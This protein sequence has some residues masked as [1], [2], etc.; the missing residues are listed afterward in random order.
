M[1]TR[2]RTQWQFC[3]LLTVVA[4]LVFCSLA[5]CNKPRTLA[6]TAPASGT[7]TYQGKPLEGATVMF[8]K[9]GQDLTSGGLATGTTDAQ[10][11][12]S[13]QSRIGPTDVV[14]GAIQG[15][16]EVIISK[17]I[18]PGGMSEEEYKQKLAEEERIMAEKGAVP[19]DKQ[20]PPKVEMLP[21]EYSDSQKSTLKATIPA[22]GDTGLKFNLK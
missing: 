10:G 5:G 18:P 12:F 3:C 15:E 4:G 16:Y 8:R 11:N 9:Q 1:S 2:H 21:A 20:A 14:D 17:F 22:G 6:G 7:V 13:L 19:A